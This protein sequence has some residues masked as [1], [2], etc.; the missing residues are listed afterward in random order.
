MQCVWT[1]APK[2]RQSY[3]NNR[4]K[5]VISMEINAPLPFNEFTIVISL[6]FDA[7]CMHYAYSMPVQYR[8]RECQIGEQHGKPFRTGIVTGSASIN[9]GLVRLI[10]RP[11]V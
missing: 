5:A 4:K 1:D 3:L 6:I 8:G 2:Q 7:S 9:S 11:N 10:I